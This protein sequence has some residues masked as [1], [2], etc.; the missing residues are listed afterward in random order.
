[1]STKDSTWEV[2]CCDNPHNSKGIP[3]LIVNPKPQL[4]MSIL[5]SVHK[6]PQI[7]QIVLVKD[8]KE[9][10]YSKEDTLQVS[11]LF[12]TYKFEFRSIAL[13]DDLKVGITRF[14]TK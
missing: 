7:Q 12:H 8:P 2:E 14:P 9:E 5:L 11:K 4:S 13:P 6:F 3:D 1:M 10:N